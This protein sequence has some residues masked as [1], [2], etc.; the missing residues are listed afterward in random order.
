MMNATERQLRKFALILTAILALQ[1][2]WSGLRLL[3]TSEPEPI[4]PAEAS[5]RV[6]GVIYGTNTGGKSPQALVNR[7]LFW[8]GRHAYA[9]DPVEEIE[10]PVVEARGSTAINQVKLRGVYPGGIIISYKGEG[11]RI[12]LG[13]SVEDWKFTQLLPGAA[14]FSSGEDKRTLNLEHASSVEKSRGHRAAAEPA[15][16]VKGVSD[17][18]NK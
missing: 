8:Q 11:R 2:L 3:Q 17:A 5:L 6:D 18:G 16:R 13:E 7:P 10:A 15:T 9:P 14:V 1:F 12:R 4:R